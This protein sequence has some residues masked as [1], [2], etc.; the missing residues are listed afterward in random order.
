MPPTPEVR[1]AAVQFTAS[2]FPQK[3]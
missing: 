1:L 2:C 3:A